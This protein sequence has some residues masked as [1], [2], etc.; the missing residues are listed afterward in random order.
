MLRILD[1]EPES[2]DKEINIFMLGFPYIY[3]QMV[4]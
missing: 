3:A 2:E 4:C 1:I